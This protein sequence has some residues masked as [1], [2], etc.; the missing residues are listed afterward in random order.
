M[1]EEM[2]QRLREVGYCA[3]PV[4]GKACI[5]IARHLEPCQRQGY[6][7]DPLELLRGE[8]MAPPAPAKGEQLNLFGRAAA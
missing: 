4:A 1:S 7:G 3:K 6:V 5:L 8:G 2:A